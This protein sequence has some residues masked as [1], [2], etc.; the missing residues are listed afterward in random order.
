MKRDVSFVVFI[1]LA[2]LL[3]AADVAFAV[4]AAV[5]I[6]SYVNGTMLADNL[7]RTLCYVTIGA[8]SAA[9]VFAAILGLVKSRYRRK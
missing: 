6:A 8:N 5:R 7:F 3:L 1:S 4:F 2:A 9:V